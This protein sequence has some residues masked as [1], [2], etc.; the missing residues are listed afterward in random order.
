MKNT[1]PASQ[2]SEATHS[3]KL[4]TD[5]SKRKCLYDYE[6]IS[7]KG[8]YKYLF[9]YLY[10]FPYTNKKTLLLNPRLRP[11]KLDQLTN[12]TPDQMRKTK[13]LTV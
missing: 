8:K 5:F 4:A 9:T 6:K 3:T 12:N 7:K 10:T 2:I 13:R 11:I 1:I